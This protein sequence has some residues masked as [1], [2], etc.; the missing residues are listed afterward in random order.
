MKDQLAAGIKSITKDW[1]AAKRHADKEHRVRQRDLDRMRSYH[2]REISIKDAAYAVMP[3][4]YNWASGNGQ[5]PASARQIMYAARPHI[6]QR[7]T[8]E[9]DHKQTPVYFNQHLLPDFMDDH[10]DLTAGWDVVWDDRGHFAEPHTDCTIG[11]GGLAVRR[12]VGE[13]KHEI[14]EDVG[15]TTLKTAVATAG[16]THRYQAVLFL[17]KEGFNELLHR[18]GILKRYDVALMSTKGM[19]TTAARSLAERLS[20]QGIRIFVAHDFDKAG[21]SIVGTLGGNTRRYRYDEKPRVIDIGLRLADVQAMSL[22]SEPVE[23][24]GRLDPRHN[25]R[26]HGATEEECNFLVRAGGRYAGGYAGER[27]ELNAMSS[28]QLL[29][30]L[31][32]KFREHGITKVVPEGEVLDRAYRRAV[33]LAILQFALDKAKNELPDTIDIPDDLHDRLRA[34]L[35]PEQGGDDTLSWDAALAQLAEEEV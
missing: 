27:V 4:A 6:I 35:D 5:Y 24:S 22:E 7:S 9:W 30:W 3:R 31:E 8:K 20:R 28:P 23:Y 32:A 21:F 11:V 34:A 29:A 10:P 16:P 1:T 15:N 2:S 33:R 12:Y 25:L 13:W 17:E 26:D 18:S 14:N 19:S